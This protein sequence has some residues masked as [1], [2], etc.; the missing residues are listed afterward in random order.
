MLCRD[1]I[2]GVSRNF[3]GNA[4]IAR[5]STVRTAQSVTAVGKAKAIDTGA[6]LHVGDAGE[7][8]NG[9]HRYAHIN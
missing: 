6:V 7:I 9:S 2:G 4:A 1:I 8:L 5:L 3:V